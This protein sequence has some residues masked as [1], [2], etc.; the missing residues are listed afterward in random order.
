MHQAFYRGQLMLLGWTAQ[1]QSQLTKQTAQWRT[2][3][4]ASLSASMPFDCLF[5]YFFD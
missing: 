5:A 2:Q 1:N 3:D 4:R